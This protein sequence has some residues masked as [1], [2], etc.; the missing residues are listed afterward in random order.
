[1]LDDVQ[2]YLARGEPVPLELA[3]WFG[4]IIEFSKPNRQLEREGDG[5]EFL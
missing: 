2:T 3:A 4:E 1:M 5:T